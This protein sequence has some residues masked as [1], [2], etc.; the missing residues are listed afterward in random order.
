MGSRI[1][2][3]KDILSYLDQISGNDDDTSSDED[4]ETSE[5]ES[6]VCDQEILK[7]VKHSRIIFQINS[8]ILGFGKRTTARKH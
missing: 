7:Y 1:L 5:G 2:R 8:I 3:E 6:E 4:V